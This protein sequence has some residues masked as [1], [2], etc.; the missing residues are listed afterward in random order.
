M[1]YV[2]N[3]PLV[4]IYCVTYNQ[5]KYVA[6]AVNSILSQD[7]PNLEIIISDDCSTDSTFDI[8]KSLIAEYK[9]NHKVVLRQNDSNLGIT[10]HCNKVL[11]LCKGKILVAHAGDDISLPNRVSVAVEVMMKHPNVMS[12]SF[13]TEIIDS[14]GNIQDHLYETHINNGDYALLTLTEYI[15]Y[16]DF[17]LYPGASRVIR[18]ELYDSFPPL[19]YAPDE[20]VYT[21]VRSLLLGAVAFVHQPLFLY[22]WHTSNFTRNKLRKAEEYDLLR[23]RDRDLS[24]KQF[25]ADLDYAIKNSYVAEKHRNIIWDKLSGIFDNYIWPQ[26]KQPSFYNKRQLFALKQ[27]RRI[28]SMFGLHVKVE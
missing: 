8:V 19:S 13:E 3:L 26:K 16:K 1:E 2:G 7:Y 28:S 18:K 20:D 5:E 12:L 10:A 24:L 22:R 9:G 23:D 6:D 11:S 21:F 25:S 27:I 4:S 15:K 17:Y 14:E